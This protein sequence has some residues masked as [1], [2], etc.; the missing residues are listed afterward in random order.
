VLSW[1]PFE[2]ICAG[3][4]VQ[5]IDVFAEANQPARDDRRIAR[6]LVSAIFKSGD[7]GKIARLRTFLETFFR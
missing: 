7:D 1:S 2:R 4:G 3:L 6:D 5:I